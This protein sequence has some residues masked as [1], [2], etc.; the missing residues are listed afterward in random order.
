VEN[1]L[2]AVKPQT[3]TE[4]AVINVLHRTQIKSVGPQRRKERGGGG[5]SPLTAGNAGDAAPQSGKDGGVVGWGRRRVDEQVHV[6]GSRRRTCQAA[7][8]RNSQAGRATATPSQSGTTTTPA[9]LP[10]KRAHPRTPG[11]RRGHRNGRDPS[12]PR[13]SAGENRV[14]QTAPRH[15]RQRLRRCPLSVGVRRSPAGSSR[16]NEAA[17]RCQA[18]T[19]DPRAAENGTLPSCRFN[20][21]VWVLPA[22]RLPRTWPQRRRGSEIF[23]IGEF[24]ALAP[25]TGAA[26]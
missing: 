13:P 17:G 3:E 25:P 16:N 12:T 10:W 11:S 7:P 15:K 9:G 8:L 19:M 2:V 23:D 5:I 20:H 14:C 1:A 26:I 22:V 18:T 21:V 24:G 4:Q 6:R